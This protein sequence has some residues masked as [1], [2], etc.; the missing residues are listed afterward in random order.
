[1]G[2]SAMAL[3]QA[4]RAAS[5]GY[6]VLFFSLEMSTRACML[7][8]A[9][10]AAWSHDCSV[11]YQSARAN[12]LDGRQRAAY[13]RGANS[14]IGL[15]LMIDE[16]AGLTVSDIAS[17]TRRAAEHFARQGRRLDQVIID[18]IGFLVPSNRYKGNRVHEVSEITAG[19]QRLAKSEQV[20]VLALHQLNRAVEGRDNKRPTLA[21]LRDSGSVE[22]DADLV[23]FCYRA[24]YYLERMKFDDR[25][26][27]ADRLR[28]LG[29]TRN[30]LEI[31][32]AK[33]RHGPTGTVDLFCDMAANAIRDKVKDQ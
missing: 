10:D 13:E 33:Q 30:D 12:K 7:R 5:A 6:G 20:A 3:A 18:H 4:R 28:K 24:A 9:A 17:A 31:I 21:D 1:M 27:E 22:Q 26:D 29:E 16:R 23:M 25:Q 2:K 8:M 32:I 14:L 11:A 19:L 15:P